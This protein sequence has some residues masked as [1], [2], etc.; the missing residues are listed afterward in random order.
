MSGTLKRRHSARQVHLSAVIPTDPIPSSAVGQPLMCSNPTGLPHT[1]YMSFTF[2]FVCF[3]PLQT[4]HDDDFGSVPGLT[5]PS[6]QHV[7]LSFSPAS[8]LHLHTGVT[9][10]A[11]DLLPF[12]NEPSLNIT[13]PDAAGVGGKFLSSGMFFLRQYHLLC[14]NDPLGQSELSSIFSD[15]QFFL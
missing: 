8:Q 7:P 12:P 4:K 6:S 9:Q 2:F 5:I 3:L 15:H 14:P 13:L 11:E 10:T 1:F